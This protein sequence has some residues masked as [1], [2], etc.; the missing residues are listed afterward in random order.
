MDAA[1]ARSVI[2]QCLTDELL[3]AL[4]VLFPEQSPG[5]DESLDS[6]R[7]RGGQRS[8]VRLLHSLKK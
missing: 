5:L 8:V 2:A 1:H 6:I 7:Y 4:D 3:S